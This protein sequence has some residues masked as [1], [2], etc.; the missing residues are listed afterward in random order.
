[1]NASSRKASQDY[2]TLPDPVAPGSFPPSE[3]LQ[4]ITL[5]SSKTEEHQQPDSS[6]TLDSLAFEILREK[7]HQEMS[8]EMFRQGMSRC[9]VHRIL[10]QAD[11]KPHKSVYWLNSHDPD[12]DAKAKPIC[13]LYLDSRRLFEQ[14]ELVSCSDEKTGMQILHRKYPTQPAVPGKPEKIEFEYIRLGTR[15]L[16]NTFCVPTG[17]I[18]WDLGLTRTSV[19]WVNHLDHVAKQF[20]NMKKYHWVVDNLNTHWSLDLCLWVAQQGGIPFFPKSLKT[21]KQRK[22][23]LSDPEHKHVFHFTPLHGSWLNQVELFFS[24]LSRRFLKRAD[25]VSAESFEQR[26]GEW[27]KNYNQCHAHPYRW[28]FTGEPLVRA[29]PFSSTRRQKQ[30]GRA[31]FGT[32]P[33]LW[34][35]KLYPPRPYTRKP[36]LLAGNL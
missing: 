36:E 22:A 34:E 17:K 10:Q 3:R 29:T 28:T 33:P 12:F 21:G 30:Q 27:L 2:K 11:L 13:Q 35:R 24:V 1:M 14:G 9:T 5:A 6:W 4:V 25:F 20:G 26:I 7:H 23:F 16:L 32:R 8:Q 31:W 15:V 18:V 19:D